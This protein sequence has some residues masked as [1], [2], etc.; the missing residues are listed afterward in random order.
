MGH[1]RHRHRLCPSL[2]PPQQFLLQLQLV[3][4][5]VVLLLL[6]CCFDDAASPNAKVEP[7][8]RESKSECSRS[9]INYTD[10][11]SD[12]GWCVEECCVMRIHCVSVELQENIINIPVV[13]VAV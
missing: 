13:V 5:F 7:R 2:P 8:R 4:I 12:D 6:F 3:W 9:Q 11:S 10:L 1:L